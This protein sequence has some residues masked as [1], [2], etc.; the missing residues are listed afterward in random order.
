M[1]HFTDIFC[2]KCFNKTL[3]RNKPNYFGHFC[4]HCAFRSFSNPFEISWLIQIFIFSVKTRKIW[5]HYYGK[6]KLVNKNMLKSAC[7]IFFF[8]SI[9]RYFCLY[10]IEINIGCIHLYIQHVCMRLFKFQN[11]DTSL[12]YRVVKAIFVY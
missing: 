10:I 9:Y 1:Q 11:L 2:R 6:L 8:R 7:L 4:N 5:K 12:I 3:M